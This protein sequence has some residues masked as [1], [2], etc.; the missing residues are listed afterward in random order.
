[1]AAA[2]AIVAE[3]RAFGAG[4]RRDKFCVR[5][6]LDIIDRCETSGVGILGIEGFYLTDTTTIPQ[7]DHI[8]DLSAGMMAYDV[9]RQFLCNSEGLP[10]FY[11]FTFHG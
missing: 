2:D 11:E 10:L 9:A 3:F 4:L 8:L 5:S 7:L 6:A 1:M